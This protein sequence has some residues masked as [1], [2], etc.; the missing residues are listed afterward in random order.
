MGSDK[1]KLWTY[2]TQPVHNVLV[3]FEVI[4][5]GTFLIFS[6][7]VG[8]KKKSQIGMYRDTS[9]HTSLHLPEKKNL[10]I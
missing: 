8:Q 7:L 9:S 10:H 6:D 5:S 3:V 4:V 1:L 2:L